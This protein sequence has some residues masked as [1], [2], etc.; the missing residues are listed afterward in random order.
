M[1]NISI[2]AAMSIDDRVIGKDGQ[3]PWHLPAE[4]AHFKKVTLGHPVLMGRKTFISIGRPLPKRRNLILSHQPDLHLP[5]CEVYSSLEKALSSVANDE[6]LM[7]IGGAELFGQTLAIANYMYLTFI[8]GKFEGDAF[9]PPWN[10][11]EW[12]ET[13]SE[14]F[15][16]DTNNPYSFRM[17]KFSRT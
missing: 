17:V 7:V 11:N 15:L 10:Q 8:D 3:M 6:E 13:A 2:V 1:M 5:G 9:F 16:K 4:L 12:Q 14:T